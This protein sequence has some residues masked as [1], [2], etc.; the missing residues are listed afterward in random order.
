LTAALNAEFEGHETM[1]KPVLSF[2]Y[3]DLQVQLNDIELYYEL[4]S[5]QV[6]EVIHFPFEYT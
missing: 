6:V 3:P 2:E 1:H 4:G 5:L